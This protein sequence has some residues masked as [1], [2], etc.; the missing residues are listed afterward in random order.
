MGMKQDDW[1]QNKENSTKGVF[2]ENFT[3]RLWK[4]RTGCHSSFHLYVSL[5]PAS[6][7]RSLHLPWY[8]IFTRTLAIEAELS[9]PWWKSCI[10]KVCYTVLKVDLGMSVDFFFL[11][12]FTNCRCSHFTGPT[13]YCTIVATPSPVE[14]YR[15]DAGMG[16]SAMAATTIALQCFI[17]SHVSS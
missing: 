2:P 6:I 1:Q 13:L 11:P 15:I 14:S 7:L 12:T 8:Y 17:L 10:S 16:A 4:R 3:Q 9:Q 5:P